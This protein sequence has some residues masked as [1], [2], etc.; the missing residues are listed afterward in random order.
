VS[1]RIAV[2]TREIPLPAGQIGAVE[3]YRR[4]SRRYGSRGVFL[5][6]SV[7][8][9]AEDTAISVVGFAPVLGV[10]VRDNRVTLTGTPAAVSAIHARLAARTDTATRS[11]DDYVLTAPDRL[12]DLMRAVQGVLDAEGSSDGFRFGFLAALGYETAR[13]VE[14]LPEVLPRNPS[15]PDLSLVLHAGAVRI[16][17]RTGRADLLLHD[18][19]AWPVPVAAETLSLL[20][21]PPRIDPVTLIPRQTRRTRRTRGPEDGP[22]DDTTQ[23]QYVD[24]AGRCLEH[25]AAGDIYQVQIGHEMQFASDAAP[26]EIYERLRR[27]NPSPYAYLADVAGHSVVGA[28]PELFVRSAAGQV[29]M[30]PIAGTAPAGDGSELTRERVGSALR[31]DPKE[32]AEHVMLVDLCRNDIGKVSRPGSLDVPVLMSVEQYSHVMHLVSTVS[33]Q[34]APGRDA[35]DVVRATF[36][37]GTMTGAPKLR[38]MEI[39]EET[40]S[41]PR[42]L[43]AGAIGLIDVGGWVDLALCI[44]TLI[45]PP[46]GRFTTR[47]SAGVV[48]DSCAEA[49]W[50]ETL[51]KM[52]ACHWAVTGQEL[53]L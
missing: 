25:I 53:T 18:S 13:Y 32:I 3:T 41:S 51:A 47:A 17:H 48:A 29:T 21:G 26:L 43:Y 52:G 42:G 50:Q 12:W 46:G 27:R 35:W 15:L 23:A 44:R 38:A 34:L 40:E 45:R 1:A 2:T 30:R 5:L 4:L 31:R 11:G 49:E 39:I 37:A 24:R 22:V 19:A 9:P 28:S 16:D 14:T 36:P 6:E 20:T 8:G 7:A 33:G 10:T